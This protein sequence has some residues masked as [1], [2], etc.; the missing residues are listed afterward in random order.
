[1]ECSEIKG[2]ISNYINH[3]C[4]EDDATKIE[5]HLCIC[6]TCRIFLSELME[7]PAPNLPT[8]HTPTSINKR[9]G[10]FEYTTIAIGLIVLA[11][12]IFFVIKD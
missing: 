6:S 9:L 8:K 12:F 11:I 7:R 3:T 2:I 10:A 1:M 5:E 4:S